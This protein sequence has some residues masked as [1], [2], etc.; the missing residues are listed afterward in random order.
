MK[1]TLNACEVR[2]MAKYSWRQ[3]VRGWG[4]VPFV[5]LT[6]NAPFFRWEVRR[7]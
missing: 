2:E 6:V 4:I 1:S 5:K 7:G 3:P